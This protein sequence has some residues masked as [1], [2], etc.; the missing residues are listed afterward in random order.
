MGRIKMQFEDMINKGNK[1]EEIFSKKGLTKQFLC[2]I[3]AKSMG[4]RQA[5]RQRTLTPSL[6]RFES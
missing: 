3:I 2:D 1:I 4:H 6:P 5:V